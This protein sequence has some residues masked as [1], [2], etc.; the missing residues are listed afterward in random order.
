MRL[1]DVA[2]FVHLLGLITLFI[3]FGI[4]QRAGARLRAATTTGDVRR[5][6]GLLQPTA[7][8]FPSAALMV[9]ATGLYMMAQA[10]T[11]LTP[12]IA[13]G[14]MSLVVIA[15]A[16]SG[17]LRPRLAAIATA[18]PSDGDEAL[19]HDL[20]RRVMDPVMWQTAAAINGI[21]VATVWIMT[22]KTDW[23]GSISVVAA[24]AIVG[25]LVG[26]AALR[27]NTSVGSAYGRRHDGG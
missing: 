23:I 18:V 20:A 9:L 15:G 2:L 14:L 24:A 8:M 17:M 1:Y 13:V 4:L 25:A 12:W 16:A 7:R 6:I 11:L 26:R 19:S 10:W 3:A 5:W 22:V 21:A 27:P